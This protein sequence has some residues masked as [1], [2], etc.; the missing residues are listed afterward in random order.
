[1]VFGMKYHTRQC[2]LCD[3]ENL[4]WQSCSMEQA[5]HKNVIIFSYIWIELIIC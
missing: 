5:H 4:K 3:N 1:M 2:Q